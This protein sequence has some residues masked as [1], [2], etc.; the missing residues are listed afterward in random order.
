MHVAESVDEIK[1]LQGKA[2]GFDRLYEK[3]GWD[4]T[5]APRVDSPFS[6]LEQLGLLGPR[7]LAVH[8]VQA[9]ESDLQILKKA[10]VAVAHCPR[11]NKETGAGRMRLA[12]FLD[13]GITVGL[14]TDSLA[15][16]PSLSMWDEMRYALRIHKRDGVTAR[17]V[18]ELA[19]LGGAKALG[20]ER[21]IGTLEPGKRADIIAVPVP[22]R[23]TGDIYS[24]LL[25]ET[26]SCIMTMVN[27][28]ILWNSKRRSARRKRVP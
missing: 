3:A 10:K 17:D 21:E 15:S 11:S 27:G 6:Y 2:S 23:L 1:F 28:K 5:W 20:W 9:S 22:S 19:T 4:R 26:N 7:F 14:G 13:A 16:S 8:A 18:F 12:K 25:R 24:D